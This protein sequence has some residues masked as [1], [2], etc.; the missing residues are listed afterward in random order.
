MSAA[1][2]WSKGIYVVPLF[3]IAGVAINDY[4][5]SFKVGSYPVQ[6]ADAA[7]GTT[8]DAVL[9]V[10]AFDATCQLEDEYVER[11]VQQQLGE[12]TPPNLSPAQRSLL[13]AE[14]ETVLGEIQEIER[15]SRSQLA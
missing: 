8:T 6:H 1:A 2:F 14:R 11:R 4:L 9:I 7:A 13:I 5:K 3:F 12:W 15:K 10:P